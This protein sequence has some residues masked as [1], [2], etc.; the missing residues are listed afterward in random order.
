MN[1]SE[2]ALRHQAAVQTSPRGGLRVSRAPRP[3]LMLQSLP[4]ERAEGQGES[5]RFGDTE[6]TAQRG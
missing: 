5:F 1:A 4:T 6:A 3:S 2:P